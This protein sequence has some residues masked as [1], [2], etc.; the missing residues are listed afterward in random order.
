MIDDPDIQAF[1]D[2]ERF[3]V[4]GASNDLNKYGAKVLRCYQQNE[5]EVYPVHPKESQIQGLDAYPSLTALPVPVP[6]AS[7]NSS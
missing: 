6:A 2:C 7:V 4:V 3:A 1:L 5:R